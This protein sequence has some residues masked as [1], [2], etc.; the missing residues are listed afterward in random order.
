MACKF[1]YIQ[2]QNI[3]ESEKDRLS[4][5]HIN[6]FTEAL[7]S[8]A[9]RKF[10]NKLYPLRFNEQ[11]AY[12][13]VAKINSKY[14]ANIASMEMEAIGKRKL[15]VNTLPLSNEIQIK[16]PDN[17]NQNTLDFNKNIASDNNLLNNTDES[18]E[19]FCLL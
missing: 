17:I 12:A 14:N 3:S 18:N 19:L 7:K 2:K 4:E 15:K 10:N 5:I 13:F 6:V 9:F 16:L 8:K 11:A 1:N